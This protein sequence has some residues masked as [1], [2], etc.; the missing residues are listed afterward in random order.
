M[1]LSAATRTMDSDF[2][3]WMECLGLVRAVK[4]AKHPPNKLLHFRQHFDG[5]EPEL[6]AK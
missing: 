6:L 5:A 1:D 4:Q 2:L 3:S